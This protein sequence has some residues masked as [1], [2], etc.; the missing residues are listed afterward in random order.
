[1]VR[2][3]KKVISI[4]LLNKLAAKRPVFHSEDDFKFSLAQLF[5]SES[6]SVRLEVPQKIL[7]P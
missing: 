3:V 1:M 2:M 7:V 6:E 5:Y 4:Q